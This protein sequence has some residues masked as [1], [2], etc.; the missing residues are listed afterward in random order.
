MFFVSGAVP[1]KHRGQEFVYKTKIRPPAK[2]DEG[3][4]ILKHF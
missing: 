4:S 3:I 1:L 2:A